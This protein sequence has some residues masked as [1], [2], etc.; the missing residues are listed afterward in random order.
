MESIIIISIGKDIQRKMIV[1][2]QKKSS[3][4]K[5]SITGTIRLKHRRLES[6]RR[7]VQCT[8]TWHGMA[9]DK[10]KSGRIWNN[11]HAGRFQRKSRRSLE[12]SY[13]CTTLD[14]RR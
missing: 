9:C 8:H 6:R 7:S 14:A 11:E 4:R 1:G 2:S 13:I 5:P 10:E 3:R 12:G